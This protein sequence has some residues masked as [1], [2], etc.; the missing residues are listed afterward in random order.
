[1]FIGDINLPLYAKLI[2]GWYHEIV[3]ARSFVMLPLMSEEKLVGTVYGDYSKPRASAPPGLAEGSMLEWRNQM[4][5][6]LQSGP[7]KTSEAKIEMAT[8]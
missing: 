2:P 4:V 3:G 7:R 8:N 1:M 5:N 6:A